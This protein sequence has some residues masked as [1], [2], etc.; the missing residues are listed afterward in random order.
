LLY[1]ILALDEREYGPLD[2]PTLKLWMLEQRATSA[3]MLIDAK[4]RM[5]TTLGEVLQDTDQ[6]FLADATTMA[7]QASHQTC[8]ACR[9]VLPNEAEICD[10]CG[11]LVP[12][13]RSDTDSPGR[14]FG[15][16]MMVLGGI[17]VFLFGPA[18][19]ILILVLM[20]IFLHH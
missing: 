20:G 9:Q 8:M 1:Y 11:I 17:L 6:D 3:T 12:T 16:V 18:L 7:F 13:P 14:A 15:T 4:T 5:K 2:L 10:R 19:L